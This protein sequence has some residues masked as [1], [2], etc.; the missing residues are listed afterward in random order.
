[1]EQQ[2]AEPNYT[3]LFLFGGLMPKNAKFCL[4]L[5]TKEKT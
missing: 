4:K 2:T 5:N 1:M 3:S